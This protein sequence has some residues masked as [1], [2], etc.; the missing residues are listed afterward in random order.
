MPTISLWY[1][2][3]RCGWVEPFV[4]STV[5]LVSGLTKET[6]LSV[7]FHQVENQLE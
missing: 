2:G 3:R 5:A 7:I 4:Q 6:C 1:N